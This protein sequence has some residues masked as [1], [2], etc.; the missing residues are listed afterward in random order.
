VSGRGEYGVR[1]GEGSYISKEDI[2]SYPDPYFIDLTDPDPNRYVIRIF[3][4][5]TVFMDPEHWNSPYWF[6]L[7][8][9]RYPTVPGYLFF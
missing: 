9:N 8:L 2:N 7:N 5:E 3:G 6:N 1:G 4:S